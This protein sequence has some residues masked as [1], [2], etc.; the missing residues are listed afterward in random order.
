MNYVRRK[1]SIFKG[2]CTATGL[3]F[4]FILLFGLALR[5]ASFSGITGGDDMIYLHDI[6]KVS[7]GDF[8]PGNSH[9]NLRVGIIFPSALLVRIFGFNEAALTIFSF[10]CSLAGIVLIY[11]FARLLFDEKTALWAAFLLS[12]FPMDVIFATMIF[13]DLPLAFFM[14]LSVFYFLQGERQRK[15]QYY[16]L[17]GVWLGVSYLAKV[18]GLYLSLFFILYVIIEK[19]VKVKY[20]FVILGFLCVFACESGYYHIQTGNPGYRFSILTNTGHWTEKKTQV[21]AREQNNSFF[22]GKSAEGLGLL[23]GNNWFLEPIFTFTTNQEF[24]FFYYFIFPIMIYLI[25]TRDKKS[26]IL[27]IWMIPVGLYI[28]Y[29]S[30]SPFSFTPLRRWPR[31]LFPIVLP[32]LLILAYFLNTKKDWLWK[33]FSLLT[34]GFLFV[35]SLMCIFWFNDGPTDS[36]IVKEIAEFRKQNPQKSLLVYWQMY[37]HLSPFLEY[38]KDINLKLYGFPEEKTTTSRSLYY[39]LE[40]VDPDNVEDAY[41]VVPLYDYGVKPQQDHPD[42]KVIHSIIRPKR[43]YCPLLE[44]PPFIPLGVKEKLCPTEVCKIYAIP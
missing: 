4:F 39:G 42:W 21:E 3:I 25:I 40:L 16:L 23:R 36:Y 2:T 28:L 7:H 26:K 35:T 29:G 5:L 34:S 8:T 6:Y 27:L 41:I 20:V 44:E 38:R 30:T 22:K 9:W 37:Q 13:G 1:F 18:T 15:P 31:Y 32:S 10:M 19:R 11:F 33:K 24:G 17:S 12:F 43:F 14:G